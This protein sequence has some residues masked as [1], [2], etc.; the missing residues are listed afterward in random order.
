M[1]RKS[2]SILVVMMMLVGIALP[3]FFS[4]AE[5]EGVAEIQQKT[6]VPTGYIG[7]YSVEDLEK[8]RGKLSGKYILMNDLD[9]TDAMNEGGAFYNDGIGWNPI[10]DSASPFTG[11]FD[12]NGYAIDGLKISLQSDQIIYAGLFGYAKKAQIM[13][14]G[15][16]NS[17]ILAENI[18]MDSSTSQVYAGGI[19]GYGYNITISNS[20]HTGKVSAVSIFEG[21]A[22]GLIGYIYTD[23]NQ[24]SMISNSSNSG[25]IYAKT[26]AG[27]LVG[28][29][30]RTKLENVLN[31]GNIDGKSSQYAGGIAGQLWSSSSVINANNTG[32][33]NYGSKGGGIIGW[34]NSSAVSD[35]YNEG[36]ISSTVSSSDGG[37][38]VG[39][40]SNS[41]IKKTHN[42]GDI[43]NSASSSTGGGIVGNIS[44]STSVINSY[45]EADV[46]VKAS[47]GGIIGSQNTSSVISQSYNT[48]NISGSNAG[49]ISGWFYGAT[50]LDSFNIGA[51]KAVY[52]AGGIVAD[53]Q[54]GTIKNTYNSS[55]VNAGTSYQATAG[56][57][58]GEYEGTI[59]NSY[60]L[61]IAQKGVGIGNAEG[62]FKKNF[63]ELKER[64]TFEG[65]NFTSIWTIQDGSSFLFPSFTEAPGSY[66]E[67]S[68]NF[69]L[70]LLPDKVTYVQ[71][72]ELDLSGAK[73]SLKT[74]HGQEMAIPVTTEM[75]SGYNPNKIGNQLL[76][77]SYD[78]LSTTFNI[79]L[80]AKYNVVFKSFDGTVLKTEVVVDGN[81]AT[82]PEPPKRE[83]YTFSGWSANFDKV[84][85]NLIVE[86]KY[87]IINYS[88]AY[89]DGETILETVVYDY[90]QWVPRPMDPVK[91]GY[92]FI[93]WYRDASFENLFYFY[94]TLFSEDMNIY[95]KFIKNPNPVQ[96][97]KVEVVGFD[98]VKVSWTPVAGVSEYEIHRADSATGNYYNIYSLGA[99]E[100][101]YIIDELKPNTTYYFKMK[102]IKSDPDYTVYSSDSQI[103]KATPSLTGVTSVK[104]AS[105]GFDKVKVSWAKSSEATGYEIYRAATSTGTYNLVGTVTSGSTL[106]YINSTLTTGRSYHYKVRAYRL[107]NG[108]KIYSSFSTSANAKPILAAVTSAKAVSTGYSKNKISWAQVSGA[109]GYEIHRAT[110]KTGTY[111][112]IKT[113]SG[114]AVLTYENTGLTTGKNYF[115]KVRAYRMVDGVKIYGTY[116]GIVNAIPA[117]AKPLKISAAKATSTSIKT[118]WSKV[119]EASGYEVYRATSQTG[120][121]TKVKTL[122]SASTVTFTNTGLSKGKTYYYKVRAYRTVNGKKIYSPYTNIASIRL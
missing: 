104:A 120:T 49:G 53:G 79:S 70:S 33:I 82:A 21:H 116:S 20:Y 27:G 119:S 52:Y 8:I 39:R 2:I 12:G 80:K 25:E 14:L 51:V 101:S 58:A 90:G 121:Y 74:N 112:N 110:S 102:T 105:G 75:V 36:E 26:A 59:E 31:E 62:T 48:G 9:L 87:T 56:G 41:I 94:E 114:A 92:T 69:S 17:V 60:Y 7:V 113:I 10:G 122:I 68:V 11:T 19:V 42:I 108:K 76:K 16:E 13:N 28:E 77:V 30:Q 86:A 40:A 66:T 6:E 99:K 115:Y 67:Q 95:A 23:Y 38:I 34:L 46:I 32:N 54:K 111:S 98:K 4:K 109:S 1:L 50:I 72:E 96:N 106:S 3:G 45:N 18:S 91:P 64:S 83:G 84:K 93:S 100:T 118:S 57:I 29:A 117:L 71:G 73:S 85:S 97:Y 88:V 43:S 55:L 65:F 89:L 61:D 44:G 103:I 35:S 22:G 81:A 15:I 107:V 47:A 5:A 24:F 78:G 37:G 63:N